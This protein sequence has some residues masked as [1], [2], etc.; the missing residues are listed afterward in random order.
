MC[1]RHISRAH[2]PASR[3]V[4]TTRAKPQLANVAFFV[5]PY[6]LPSHRFASI[7]TMRVYAGVAASMSSV[8]NKPPLLSLKDIGG[9][10]SYRDVGGRHAT[11]T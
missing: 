5:L 9:Q 1:Y 6:V 7:T 11:D 2:D 10:W 3:S 8:V 4:L